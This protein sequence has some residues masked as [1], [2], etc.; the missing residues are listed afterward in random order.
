MSMANERNPGGDATG[1]LQSLKATG[2]TSLLRPENLGA[3]VRKFI[4]GVLDAVER[5]SREQISR[6]LG[7][8]TVQASCGYFAGI[9]TGRI[10]SD[11]T[12]DGKW[13]PDGLAAHLRQELE[14]D[15]DAEEVI[16][17]AFS[18][19]AQHVFQIVEIEGED[20]G[21]KAIDEL[22]R[23]SIMLLSGIK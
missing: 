22:V 7:I 1:L 2:E 9:L 16:G 17:K 19:I 12:V 8:A 5:A 20:E 10:A 21:Q 4:A 18:A 11:Y 15:G 23:A 14:T 13:F 3:V 6:E